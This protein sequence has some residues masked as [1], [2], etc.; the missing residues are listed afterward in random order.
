MTTRLALYNRALQMIGERGIASLSVNEKTRR[1]LDV[2]WDNG[3]VDI[4]LAGAQWNFAMRTVR[5][6]Y[7][8]SIEPDFGYQ[9][10]FNIPTDFIILSAFC[11]DEY[12]RSPIRMYEEE[13]DQWYSDYDAVYVRYVSNDAAYGGDLGSWPDPF[14]DFVAAHFAT[15]IVRDVTDNASVIANFINLSRPD[16][17]IRGRKLLHAKSR[18]AMGNPSR[19]LAQGNWSQSRLGG[20]RRD[21]GSYNRLI[22]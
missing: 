18:N 13:V 17:T 3:G 5:I 6:D 9:H 22:G 2:V 7:D 21:G 14:S 11:A 20:G 8:P 16:H 10:A 19:S 15:E 4:C 1:S 12:F